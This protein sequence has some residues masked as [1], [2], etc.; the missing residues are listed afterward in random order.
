MAYEFVYES[1]VKQYRS[2][3]SKTLKKNLR[4]TAGEGY[5]CTVFACWKRGKEYDHEK[6]K[7]PV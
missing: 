5:F 6:W 1:E 7:W 2:D 3:C 4:V